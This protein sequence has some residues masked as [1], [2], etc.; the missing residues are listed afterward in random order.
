MRPCNNRGAGVHTCIPNSETSVYFFLSKEQDTN[1]IEV[2][3]KR[4]SLIFILPL[5]LLSG[6]L[7]TLT[8][9]QYGQEG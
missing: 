2:P 3:V 9:S 5:L 1:T 4:R 8:D 6:V 7:K